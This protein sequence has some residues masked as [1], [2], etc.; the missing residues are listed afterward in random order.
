MLACILY[1]KDVKTAELRVNLEFENIEAKNLLWNSNIK[2]DDMEGVNI[3]IVC[4]NGPEDEILDVLPEL[5]NKKY[6]VPVVLLDETENPVLREFAKNNGIKEYFSRDRAIWRN[7]AIKIKKIILKALS[8]DR[9]RRLHA[10][11]IWL[12]M[13]TRFA[14]RDNCI[15][16]L[17]NKEFTLLEFFMLNKG[18]I[19]TRTTILEHVWDRNAHFASNTVDV[20]IN[21]LRKKIDEPFGEKLI[22]TVPCVGYIFDRRARDIRVS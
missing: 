9:E 10:C 5:R 6:M 1:R 18:K 2:T 17:R 13:N 14:K 4:C 19:L 3:I 20:H 11:N 16:Q 21:R 8:R 15:I 22:H 7:F 12:D